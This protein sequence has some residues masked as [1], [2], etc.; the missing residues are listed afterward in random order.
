VY[1]RH[2]RLTVYWNHLLDFLVNL[3][4]WLVHVPEWL[5]GAGWKRVARDWREHKERTIDGIYMWTKK[6]VV[7]SSPLEPLPGVTE[8]VQVAGADDYSVISST[9]KDVKGWGWDEETVD[10]FAKYLGIT[11]YMGKY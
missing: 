9:L 1:K 10:E 2:T 3:L 6:R 4:P 7:S 8:L 11:L 5:P